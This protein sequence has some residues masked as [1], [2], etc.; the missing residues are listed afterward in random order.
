MDPD[1]DPDVDPDRDPDV[2]PDVDSELLDAFVTALTLV[3]EQ[4][5]MTFL[6]V[7]G[8]QFRH[9]QQQLERYEL[10]QIQVLD[11]TLD[12]L[13]RQHQRWQ[14]RLG[15]S[16][17]PPDVT[18]AADIL[19]QAGYPTPAPSNGADCGLHRPDSDALAVAS[20]QTAALA[21]QV[22][23]LQKQLRHCQGKLAQAQ[24]TLGR[25]QA[26]L[27]TA[28]ATIAQGYHRQDE[29]W[30]DR[31]LWGEHPRSSLLWTARPQVWMRPVVWAT[32]MVMV[33]V[34]TAWITMVVGTRQAEQSSLHTPS[35][36]PVLLGRLPRLT[37]ELH[38]Q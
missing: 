32:G 24:R 2:D 1:V 25:T 15:R 16:P 35:S 28:R 14:T 10:E 13:V 38:F 4:S 6:E 31:W 37:D 7:A 11:D 3:V 34:V 27:R 36:L 20:A 8:E 9:L 5:Q 30:G 22:A 33:L 23:D 12:E 29:G 26:R 21:E 17:Q 19:P 18:G